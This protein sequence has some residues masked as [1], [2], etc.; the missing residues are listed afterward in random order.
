MSIENAIKNACASVEMEGY[1][2]D[3]ECKE[4]CRLLLTGEITLEQYISFV[5]EQAEV[6]A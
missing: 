6:S 3:D 2:I 1:N 5:K 4:W